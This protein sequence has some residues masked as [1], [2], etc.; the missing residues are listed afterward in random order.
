VTSE[1]E[2]AV[3]LVGEEAVDKLEKA[4]YR[5]HR[6]PSRVLYEAREVALWCEVTPKTVLAWARAGALRPV[7]SPG[8]R[9]RFEREDVRAFLSHHGYALPKEL[10]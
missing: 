8:G 7:R 6:A 2:E 9:V 5:L 1:R 4:G 3:K 10:S